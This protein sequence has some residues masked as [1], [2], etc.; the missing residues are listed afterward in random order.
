MAQ[1]LL[2]LGRGLAVLE[3]I[4]AS[5]RHL[6]AKELSDSSG[7]NLSTTYQ[8]LRTLRDG[9]YIVRHKGGGYSL[10]PA[11]LRI[12]GQL[13]AMPTLPRVVED[14]LNTL[15][16]KTGETSYLVGWWL[17]R[18]V[19]ASILE[20][21]HALRVGRLDV[22]Y[23]G[24]PHARASCMSILAFLTSEDVRAY[25]ADFELD[26]RT[27]FTL[28]SIEA[29][30]SKLRTIRRQGYAVDNQEFA[31]GIACYSAPVFEAGGFPKFSL[32]V[33]LPVARLESK[34]TDIINEVL[35]ASA[36]ASRGLGYQG[37]L[38]NPTVSSLVQ[39][40][41]DPNDDDGSS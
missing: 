41:A 24:T 29:I 21:A 19:M 18:I 1:T 2:T 11:V 5:D 13:D 3:L 30:E 20:G 38:P 31:L 16:E 9:E 17:S 10:G 14:A 25:L 7:V 27:S 8:V 26:R 23:S 40:V 37:R 12:A 28:D 15:F 4:A 33:S 22:G 35:R 39:S 32:T 34:E 36:L 6:T